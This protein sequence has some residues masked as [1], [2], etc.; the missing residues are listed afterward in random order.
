MKKLFSFLVLLAL[1]TLAACGGNE[2]TPESDGGETTAKSGSDVSISILMSKPEIA[3]PFE[4]ATADFTSETGIKVSVITVGGNVN[5]YE[6]LTSLY[7]SGNAPT[8]S[9]MTSEFEEFQDRLLDLTDQS[10]VPTVQAGGTDY[11]TVDGKVYG[12]PLTVEAFGFIYNKAVLDEAVGGDFDPATIRTQDDLKNLFEQL[13]A[14]EDVDPIHVSPMDWSLGAH[15]TNMLFATQS[16][17]RTERHQFMQD[18]IDGNVSLGDNDVVNGWLA[19]FDL[20][21]EYNSEA[22]SPLAPQYED[23]P[24][25]LASGKVGLWFMGNWAY[26]QLSE[27]DPDGEYGFLPVPISDDAGDY[28]NA[29][30]SVGVPSYWVVDASQNTEEQQEAAKKFLE[31]L[32]TTDAGQ[33]HYVEG[34]NL[35]PVFQNFSIHPEDPLSVSIV[36]YMNDNNTLEWINSYYPADAWAVLGASMQKYLSDNID[37]EGLIQEFEDYWTS[38]K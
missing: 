16:S 8:I 12:M 2:E 9:L 29:Q 34:L 11:V 26:P 27:I 15:F 21:K 17:D 22:S 37:K 23:G 38:V 19:T 3:E 7:S 33:T 28:G 10:W 6:R 5:P 24:L 32:V 14:M 20:M 18:V 30:I 4:A 35:I 1:L 25:A 13:E 36:D 31:W